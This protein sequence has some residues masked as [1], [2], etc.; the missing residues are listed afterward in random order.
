MTWTQEAPIRFGGSLAECTDFERL[1]RAPIKKFVT[2]TNVRTGQGHLFRNRE[3]MPDVLLAPTCLPT[4]FQA[5]EIDGENY[6]E[7]AIPRSSTPCGISSSCCVMPGVALRITF[8]TRTVR[9]W[10]GASPTTLM[11]C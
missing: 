1:G 5:F 4:M 3:I 11:C 6:W 9:I 2:V 8:L 7:A 10:N